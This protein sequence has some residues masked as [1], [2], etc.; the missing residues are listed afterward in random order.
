MSTVATV[1]AHA[2]TAS[3]IAS[4]AT[5]SVAK[6]VQRLSGKVD[7]AEQRVQILQ[8]DAAK[9]FA[10]QEQQFTRFQAVADRIH[11]ILLPR[12]EAL[13]NVTVFQDIQQSVG[14]ELRGPEARGFHSRTTTLTVPVSDNHPAR[15]QFSLRVSH[16]GP[17]KNAVVAYRFE[18]LPIFIK[19]DSRVELVVPIDEP[20]DETT[21]NMTRRQSQPGSSQNIS[22]SES[23]PGA[24]PDDF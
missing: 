21:P 13:T 24:R 19:L 23:S 9:V 20:S 14:V 7:A 17:M 10:L 22:G 5:S 15:M 16:D 8:A 12:L 11:A 2:E 3:R 6:L 4:C 18:I 1:K